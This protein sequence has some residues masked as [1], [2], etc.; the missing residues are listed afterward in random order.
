[1]LLLVLAVAAGVLVLAAVAGAVVIASRHRHDT[2]KLAIS[3]SVAPS[4]SAPATSAPP[5]SP[6]TGPGPTAPAAQQQAD[7]AKITQLFAGVNSAWAA[8]R[9][10]GIAFT[11]AHSY[12]GLA[13]TLPACQ[14]DIPAGETQNYQLDT[15]TFAPAPS[16]QAMDG[17][18]VVVAVDG[19]IYEVSA[20]VT[21]TDPG[22]PPAVSTSPVHA[23][24]APDGN[25]YMFFL[26]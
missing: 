14:A 18:D 24:V 19:R 4:T 6:T 16:F 13:Q 15:K 26:C 3:T 2:K 21:V 8:G 1:M 20:T 9:D 22:K 12:P 5:T 7:E 25:A 23:V 17:D 11:V 10:E